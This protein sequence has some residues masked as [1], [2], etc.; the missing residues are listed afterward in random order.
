MAPAA[1]NCPSAARM[2]YEKGAVVV[3]VIAPSSAKRTV[4]NS[5]LAVGVVASVCLLGACS[6]KPQDEAN[7][8]AARHA[9]EAARELASAGEPK[10]TPH[11]IRSAAVDAD[12]ARLTAE[13]Q[14][15]FAKPD[16]WKIYLVQK[17]ISDDLKEVNEILSSAISGGERFPP[18]PSRASS[19]WIP[20]TPPACRPN[21]TCSSSRRC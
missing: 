16:D 10:P 20:G 3:Y 6:D 7:K 12:A 5:L 14:K 21:W 4:W 9:D 2:A 1:C 8:V 11:L 17:P 15:G 13:L 18:M 19:S